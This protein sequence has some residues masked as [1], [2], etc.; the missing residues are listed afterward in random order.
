MV[1]FGE[2]NRVFQV[3]QT[4]RW[5]CRRLDVQNFCVRCG[6]SLDSF[7][8]SRDLADRDAHIGKKIAHQP[9]GAAVKLRRR[10]HFIA[11]LQSSRSAEEMA[12]IPLEVT[13]A[14]SAPSSAAIFSSAT[15]SV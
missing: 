11:L 5:I 6:E 2:R 1:F 9:I 14:A 4:Q 13:T 8:R 10:N 12:A 3:H 15:V 7:E